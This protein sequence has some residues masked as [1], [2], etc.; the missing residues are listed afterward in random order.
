MD[1]ILKI[2]EH[3]YNE[4]YIKYRHNKLGIEILQ[5]N[6][7]YGPEGNLDAY[8]IKIRINGHPFGLIFCHFYSHD[9]LFLNVKMLTDTGHTW[10]KYISFDIADPNSLDNFVK[11]AFEFVEICKTLD[12]WSNT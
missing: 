7:T 10:E 8:W 9:R 6:K 12:N 1:G 3:L 11:K 5:D 4:L 2:G